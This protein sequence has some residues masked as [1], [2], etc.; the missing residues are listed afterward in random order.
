MQ[1]LKVSFTVKVSTG[2]IVAGA[3]AGGTKYVTTELGGKSPA[4]VLP[5]RDVGAAVD[6]AMVVKL[7]SSGQVTI[8]RLGLTP[9][10]ASGSTSSTG[11]ELTAPRS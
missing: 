5:Y 3:A 6:G 11:T 4:V 9:A 8:V 1:L 2:K 10:G 7:F